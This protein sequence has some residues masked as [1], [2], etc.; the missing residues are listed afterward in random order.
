MY[1]MNSG[2]VHLHNGGDGIVFDSQI[3]I[4]IGHYIRHHIG[5]FGIKLLFKIYVCY[6]LITDEG[7]RTLPFTLSKK[8]NFREIVFCYIIFNSNQATFLF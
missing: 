7:Q 6:L 1:T 2:V 8:K 5:K 3:V 4:H